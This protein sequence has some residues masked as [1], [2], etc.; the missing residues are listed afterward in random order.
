MAAAASSALVLSTAQA[1]AADAV[2][3]SA[4]ASDD[5]CASGDEAC[6]LNALQM[7][8]ARKAQESQRREH[9]RA[10]ASEARGAWS[11]PRLTLMEIIRALIEG[12]QSQP[13]QP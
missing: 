3:N 4:L 2:V 12:G 7:R 11:M 8:G 9:E 10:M 6:A 13:T 5:Q 1:S